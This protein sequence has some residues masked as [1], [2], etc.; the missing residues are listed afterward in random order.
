MAFLSLG[1]TGL[2]APRVTAALFGA[3]PDSTLS[4][5]KA[6][7]ARNIGLSIL[8]LALLTLGQPLAL[9]GLLLAAALIAFLDFWIVLGAA[10]FP[11]AAKHLGYCAALLALAFWLGFGG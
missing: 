10:S 8:A 2:F 4:F 11:H 1:L 9:T 6:M 3:G 7:G 5:V